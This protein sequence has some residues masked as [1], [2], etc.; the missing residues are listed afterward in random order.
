MTRV[1]ENKTRLIWSINVMGLNPEGI[2]CTKAAYKGRLDILMWVQELG[3]HVNKDKNIYAIAAVH[4]HIH[5]LEWAREQ[6]IPWG[7]SGPE[8]AA[9]ACAAA[10]RSGNLKVL[11]WLR[12]NGCP[13]DKY[14]CLRIA[15]FREY[16]YIVYWIMWGLGYEEVL[17][18][19]VA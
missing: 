15:T 1:A 3:Y 12:R 14:R 4:G 13:W 19:I 2:L 18:P 17:Y 7:E 8:E 11:Q 16:V 10:T 9:A 5:I 6:R